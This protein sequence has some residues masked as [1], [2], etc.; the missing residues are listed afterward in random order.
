[1][2][3]HDRVRLR[4]PKRISPSQYRVE[5]NAGH[6]G[7]RLPSLPQPT[8]PVDS[9]SAAPRARGRRLNGRAPEP[10]TARA[11]ELFC[12][13]R[14]RQRQLAAPRTGPIPALRFD[15]NMT[16]DLDFMRGDPADGV[17]P[18]PRSPRNREGR[19]RRSVESSLPGSADSGS[20][21]RPSFSD[22]LLSGRDSSNS[23]DSI[24][25]AL[26]RDATV[27]LEEMAAVQSRPKRRSQLKSNKSLDLVPADV[28]MRY[29]FVGELGRGAFGVVFDGI[30]L[31]T[32]EAVAI[33]V[34]RTNC[35][36]SAGER[37]LA[38]NEAELMQRAKNPYIVQVSLAEQYEECVIIV[39]ERCDERSL[40][41]YVRGTKGLTEFA[42]RTLI[43]QTLRALDY[44]HSELNI[45][46]RDLKPE[47]I[48]LKS[49]PDGLPQIK[50]GDFGLA[51]KME[52]TRVMK[53]ICGTPA[54]IAP[55]VIKRNG[56]SRA[57]DCWSVGV[58]IFY[59]LCG[60]LPFEQHTPLRDENGMDPLPDL[61]ALSGQRHPAMKWP[62]SFPAGPK[63][64]IQKLL[65]VNPLERITS[66]EALSHYWITGED[67]PTETEERPSLMQMLSAYRELDDDDEEDAEK[68]SPKSPSQFAQSS[69]LP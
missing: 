57:V 14:V 65:L 33:K 36:E 63:D 51:T 66:K 17:N 16:A 61:D 7:I 13:P 46:H 52:S 50:L 34:I 12:S 4:N 31:E 21:R 43:T 62:D 35:S 26:A 25:G 15:G 1:M 10:P 23:E 55:E 48:L 24:E 18:L 69:S 8:A 41:D 27:G 39:M 2:R 53:L 42:C 45:V 44:L 68:S 54:Y 49:G 58:M 11:M 5:P 9:N 38:L 47:N 3:P 67:A 30:D 56:Y 32:K 29:K 22:T 60:V 6:A 37:K 20:R 40:E 19:R 28:K 59:L 64:L